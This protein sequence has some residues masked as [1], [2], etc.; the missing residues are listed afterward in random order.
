VLAVQKIK[1]ESDGP[2][3]VDAWQRKV[4]IGAENIFFYGYI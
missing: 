3:S 1:H 4:S 2:A